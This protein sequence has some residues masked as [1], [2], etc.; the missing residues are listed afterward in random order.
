M[1][2]SKLLLKTW[3][4]F[5]SL[6]GWGHAEGR[7]RCHIFT[8]NTGQRG[9]YPTTPALTPPASTH[10]EHPPQKSYR[11]QTIRSLSCL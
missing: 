10:T 1:A 3:R 7:G 9:C 5:R 2:P 11:A 8:H 6:G 4:Q